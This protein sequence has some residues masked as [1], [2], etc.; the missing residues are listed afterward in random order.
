MATDYISTRG[1]APALGFSDAMLAGLAR[2]GGLYVPREWPH[3]SAGDIRAMRGLSYSEIAYRVLSP[4]VGDEIAPATLR[5][6]IEESYATFRHPAVCPLVQTGPNEFILELFHGPTLAFKDVA[7]QLLARLMDHVLAERGERVTIVG[8][9][10]GDT[11]GA[12]IEAFAGTERADVFILFPEGRVSPVQ[13]RQMTTSGAPNVHALAVKGNFDDCQA[14]L[15]DMF[16]DHAFRDGVS[17]SGVNSINWA[18]VM[19]QIVYYFT[20]ALSLGG[21]DRAISFTVP[22]GN[23]GDIFAGY[24]AKRMGLPVDQ[25]VIATNDNDILARTLATGEYATRGVVPTTSPSMDIQVSSNFERLLYFASGGNVDEIRR[26]MQSL[27]QSGS[28][29]VEEKTLEA[30]RA[31]FAAGRSDMAETAGTIGSVLEESGYLLDPHTATGVKVA[32]GLE[33]SSAPMVVLSTAHPA[34]FP[35]AVKDASGV[36]PPLPAWLGDLMER[37]ESF[38]VVPSDLK[39]LQDHISRHARAAR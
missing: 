22:T 26:Y 20:A 14:L 16:N 24:A 10:S 15:K 17:L 28:F 37:K 31:E 12:A 36:E 3:F 13:Q 8:A 35:Q 39:L 27:K 11:G 6:I 7:M 4:F 34:K 21:P 19:A 23:F 2:D 5:R 30:I 18:R 38:T 1:D 32:R 9:T 29:T 25:L 33:A